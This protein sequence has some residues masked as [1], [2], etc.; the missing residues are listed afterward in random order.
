MIVSRRSLITG[1]TSI[2]AAPAIVRA[3]SLMPIRAPKLITYWDWSYHPP[4][5]IAVKNA[6]LTDWARVIADYENHTIAIS[7]DSTTWV[8][9]PRCAP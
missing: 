7:T 6:V 9:H 1:I 4:R 3:E 8:V 5:L 2:I